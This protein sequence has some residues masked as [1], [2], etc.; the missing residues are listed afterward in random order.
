M[1]KT[2][3]ITLQGLILHWQG[4]GQD[5]LIVLFISNSQK[6]QKKVSSTIFLFL[7]YFGTPLKP[8]FHPARSCL[9]CGVK[10]GPAYKEVKRTVRKIFW[11]EQVFTI[12]RV[13]GRSGIS[14]GMT[15]LSGGTILAGWLY[16][17]SL[18]FN[19][20]KGY[21]RGLQKPLSFW[22]G[23]SYGSPM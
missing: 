20:L 10:L 8:F 16:I 13:F 7:S 12:L 2:L 15:V 21:G 22:G 11:E 1:N 14:A 17:P 19:T 5:N 4:N 6:V 9:W 23:C 3:E 18:P